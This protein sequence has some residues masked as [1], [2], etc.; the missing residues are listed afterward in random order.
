[1]AEVTEAGAVE[2]REPVMVHCGS[3]SHEWAAVYAPIDMAK[4]GEIL[5]RAICPSCG[6]RKKIFMG[7]I[8]RKITAGPDVSIERRYHAWSA[9][10][11]TGVSSKAIA[12]TMRG[13][14]ARDD[15][16][17]PH[18]S[19]DFGRCDRLLMLMPEWRTR[20]VEMAKVSAEWKA[21]S[22]RWADIEAVRAD[23]AACTK[24]IRSIIRPIED[25]R[26]GMVRMGGATMVFRV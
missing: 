24:L 7:I 23:H 17:H 6:E 8:P 5:K 12:A 25:R 20:I 2:P 14:P 10:G 9:S 18:D 4:F 26:P 11:D 16:C 3:C 19:D 1:M 13:E 15:Y 21:L 22:E